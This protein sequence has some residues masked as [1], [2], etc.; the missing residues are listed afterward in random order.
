MGDLWGRKNT[1]LVTIA[2]DGLFHLCVGRAAYLLK[3]SACW[4]RWR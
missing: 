1:F 2:A 4:R 3:A